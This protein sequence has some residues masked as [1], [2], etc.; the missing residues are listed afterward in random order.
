MSN[1][2]GPSDLLLLTLKAGEEKRLLGGHAWVFSNEL[3][4][5]PKDVE[6]GVLAVLE[7]A[8]G[9]KLGVGYYNHRSLISF[10]LLSRTPAS[11]DRA[12]FIEL[13]EAARAYRERHVPGESSYRLCYGESD[14]IPGL[15]VDKF[16]DVLVIQSNAAGI[17]R[18]L[19]VI[20]E[21]LNVLFEP[22]GIYL[23]S[24]SHLRKLEGLVPEDRLL[25]GD[26]PE[27]IVIEERG[28]RFTVGV[29]E[30]QKT[31]FYFDQR[32]NRAALAPYFPSR[33]VLDLHCFSG[34][35]ALNAAKH[36]A[37][38]VLGLDSSS[39]AIALAQENA[40]LNNLTEKCEFDSGD[41]ADLLAAFGEKRQTFVPDM[42][43]L[44]PPS[45]A[46]SKKHLPAALRAYSRLN[47]SALRVLSSGGLLATSTCSH[48]VSRAKFVEM[49]RIAAE[50]AGKRV[51]RLELR[52]QAKD[53][54]VLLSMPET[55][56]LHFALLEVM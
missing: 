52:G 9:R 51:R 29:K 27:R 36:G 1:N 23:R 21:A 32:D 5:V 41:A 24:N 19:P 50:K 46:A 40:R 56:Y 16:A 14:G 20:V 25:S 10:R 13:F 33:N 53:H 11:V 28:L 44:D 43:L 4:A 35:F 38:R 18:L 37:A 47:A 30:G 48:H 42:I 22:Q 31:G 12:F 15:I 8:K 34:A 7:T 39:D 6:P 26:V 2:K 45:F 49:L 17:E 55:E 3:K 54:P